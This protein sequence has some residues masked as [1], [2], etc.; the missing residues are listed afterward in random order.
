[1]SSAI[2]TLAGGGWVGYWNGNLRKLLKINFIIDFPVAEV[3]DMQFIE[4]ESK[5]EFY[6]SLG[7]GIPVVGAYISIANIVA[8][9]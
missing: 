3:N 7:G 1:M 4:E 2:L 6:R 8:I 5:I 9:I